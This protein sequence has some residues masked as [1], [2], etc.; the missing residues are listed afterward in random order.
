M[1]TSTLRHRMVAA[2]LT[3]A[4]GL[5]GA[6][7]ALAQP[8]APPSP[9]ALRIVMSDD[10]TE[11]SA[12][13]RVPYKLVVS[14]GSAEPATG[15]AVT[16][17]APK[18]MS[19]AD[20]TNGG[21]VD[22]SV[23]DWTLDIPARQD[24]ELRLVGVVDT[25][26]EHVNGIA[27]SSCVAAAP[28]QAP[29]VCTSDINQVTGAASIRGLKAEDQPAAKA[30]TWSWW[31]FPILAAVVALVVL[32]GVLWI[33]RRLKSRAAKARTKANDHA[34]AQEHVGAL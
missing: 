25:I 24:V 20:I 12:G 27:V 19:V 5:A 30:W 26:P 14:N 18:G 10:V 17:T 22:G 13:A 16:F 15:L 34:A 7:P 1:T 28:R 3:F 9:Q 32:A 2:A 23:V 29:L 4:A 11:T 6:A 21:T 31:Q 33:S 8:S